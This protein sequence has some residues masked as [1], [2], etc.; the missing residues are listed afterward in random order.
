MFVAVFS[1]GTL[2]ACAASEPVDL[3]SYAAI[4]DVRTVDEWNTGHLETAVLMD[5]SDAAFASNL[6][7]LDKS[8]NYYVYCR[9]GNRAGQAIEQMKKLGFTG[10]LTNGGSV[11]DASAATGLAIV[12]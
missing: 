1:L 4:I 9:S 10:T 2:T 5:I 6:E 12:Q 11:E 7:T 3:A 8:A